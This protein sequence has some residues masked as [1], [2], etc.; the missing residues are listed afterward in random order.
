MAPAEAKAFYES[1]LTMVRQYAP[2]KV[3]DGEFGAYMS[4]SIEN[5][6]PVTIDLQSISD[7]APPTSTATAA[8]P[9]PT[10]RCNQAKSANPRREPRGT[11]SDILSDID[12][13][14][15]KLK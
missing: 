5:D 4:V 10:K 12:E 9:V 13:L 14:L 3:Q 1:F 7:A 11:P 2:E 6:G 8:K 15:S